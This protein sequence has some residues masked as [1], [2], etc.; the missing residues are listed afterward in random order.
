MWHEMLAVGK[1]GEGVVCVRTPDEHTYLM[2][3]L[4]PERGLARASAWRAMARDG[5]LPQ[6]V[7]RAVHRFDR[8]LGRSELPCAFREGAR[9]VAV[10]SPEA[11]GGA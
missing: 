4:G 6:R 5:S 11:G 10:G 9:D 1:V 3:F 2:E 7:M 8:P